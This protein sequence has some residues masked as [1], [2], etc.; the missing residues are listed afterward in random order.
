MIPTLPPHMT[1]YT[2]RQY[3]IPNQTWQE[4]NP[5]PILPKTNLR[6]TP[7]S[8][9]QWTILQPLQSDQSCGSESSRNKG[10][11]HDYAPTNK[12]DH[13]I[14][15]VHIYHATEY[16]K[17]TCNNAQFHLLAKGALIMQQHAAINSGL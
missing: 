5:L 12:D 15:N 17:K 11:T 3:K 13:N 6:Q 1:D 7:S 16:G 4:Q 2:S 14:N 8:E 10:A 9:V